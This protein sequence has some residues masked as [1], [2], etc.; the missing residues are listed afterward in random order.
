M[1]YKFAEGFYLMQLF[2]NRQCH[3]H[4]LCIDAPDQFSEGK[5]MQVLMI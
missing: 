3:T 5:G 4:I 2:L 1:I